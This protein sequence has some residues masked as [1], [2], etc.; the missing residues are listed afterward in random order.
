VVLPPAPKPE[1]KP[2][3]TPPAPPAP[4][5]VFKPYG[6]EIYFEETKHEIRDDYKSIVP[7]A[8]AWCKENPDKKILVEGY[9]DKDTGWPDKNMTYS[10]NRA[11]EVAK[12]LKANGVPEDQIIIKWYGD[13]VQPREGI[14]NRVVIISG[15]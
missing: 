11:E 6:S 2:V 1:P 3:V 13:T 9:A 8:A 10:Q 5:K 4:Q 15:K 7:S 14:Q 12:Q